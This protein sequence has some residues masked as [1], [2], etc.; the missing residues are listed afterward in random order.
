MTCFR[1]NSI[2][3]VRE[4]MKWLSESFF[5]IKRYWGNM[6]AH[7][8]FSVPVHGKGRNKRSQLPVRCVRERTQD[9]SC[10]KVVYM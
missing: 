7:G 3:W 4:A 6:G 9:K 8:S 10:I 2:L 5:V 1:T